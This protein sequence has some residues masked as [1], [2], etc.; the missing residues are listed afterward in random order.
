MLEVYL[1]ENPYTN[2]IC[3]TEISNIVVLNVLLVIDMKISEFDRTSIA[4]VRF[5]ACHF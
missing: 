2:V 3:N 5:T 4:K 1:Q